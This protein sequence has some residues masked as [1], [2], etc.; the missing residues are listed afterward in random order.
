MRPIRICST[1][2]T[3]M[4]TTPVGDEVIDVFALL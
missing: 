2:E 3:A 4:V 1:A